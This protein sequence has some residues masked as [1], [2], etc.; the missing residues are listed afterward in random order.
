LELTLGGAIGC[1]VVWSV[2]IGRK[3][4]PRRARI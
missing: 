1:P 4:G 2:E 3:T